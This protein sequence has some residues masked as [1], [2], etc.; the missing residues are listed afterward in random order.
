M[1]CDVVA[2][3]ARL[4]R[5]GWDRAWDRHWDDCRPSRSESGAR[6]RA[7]SDDASM[8]MLGEPSSE[9]KVNLCSSRG[10]VR[11]MRVTLFQCRPR[12]SEPRASETHGSE[13]DSI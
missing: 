13:A 4:A 11:H 8:R 10:G 5:A 9:G 12:T 1:Q 7:A 2:R 6:D 3:A